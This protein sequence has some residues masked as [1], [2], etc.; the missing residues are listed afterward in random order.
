MYRKYQ[1][2]ELSLLWT[3]VVVGIVSLVAM[4]ALMSARFERNYF[5][6]AWKRVTG[7]ELGRVLQDTRVATES[8]MKPEGAAVRKC[9]VDG[10]VVYSNVECDVN[11][12]TSR[13]VQL[14]DTKGFEAPKLPPAPEQAEAAVTM[15]DKMIEKATGA[16][17]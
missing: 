5:A 6:E 9:M 10:R 16:G 14:H 17:R 12:S 4:V 2:G 3:A 7:S 8:T 15:Q 1:R 13:K 11:N